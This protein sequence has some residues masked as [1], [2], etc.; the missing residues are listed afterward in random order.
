M[1]RFLGRLC[2]GPGL[3][4]TFVRTARGAEG[5]LQV[6]PSCFQPSG[7]RLGEGG[8]G[9]CAQRSA[10]KQCSPWSVRSSGPFL[11]PEKEGEQP[12]E[13]LLGCSVLPPVLP[14]AWAGEERWVPYH[15]PLGAL[16]SVVDIGLPCILGPWG[17]K[18]LGRWSLGQLLPRAGGTVIRLS[19]SDD[20][21][22]VQC[23]TPSLPQVLN[24]LPWGWRS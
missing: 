14:R 22:P 6:Q 21:R 17:A 1:N 18:S 11:I 16:H 4:S 20:H 8:L 24:R 7:Q 3:P 2:S 5:E 9:G 15:P 10:E 19:P 23:R 12:W 13:L